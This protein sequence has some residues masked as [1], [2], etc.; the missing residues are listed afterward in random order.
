MILIPICR[1]Q[2]KNI[3]SLNNEHKIYCVC[4]FAYEIRITSSVVNFPRDLYLRSIQQNQPDIIR[5]ISG[6]KQVNM[7]DM[8]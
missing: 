8:L 4:K 7:A 1:W 3:L 6:G 2:P 5:L